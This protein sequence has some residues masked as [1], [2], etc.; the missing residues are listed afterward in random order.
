MHILISNLL[1]E[2]I[3]DFGKWSNWKYAN[4]RIWVFSVWPLSKVKKWYR[5]QNWNKK[6]HISILKKLSALVIILKSQKIDFPLYLQI[7]LGQCEGVI[8]EIQYELFRVFSPFYLKNHA[9]VVKFSYLNFAPLKLYP[10]FDFVLG[11][12]RSFFAP[13]TIF[14]D[15]II[16]PQKNVWEYNPFKNTSYKHH[17]LL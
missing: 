2:S 17:Q 7:L 14:W 6:V 11:I 5:K 8:L 12:F 9:R 3:F 10:I 15:A 4:M 16:S 13:Q 1:L